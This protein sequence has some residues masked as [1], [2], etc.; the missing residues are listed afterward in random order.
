METTRIFKNHILTAQN[1]ANV[2][3][4]IVAAAAKPSDR[5]VNTQQQLRALLATNP[6]LF[7]FVFISFPVCSPKKGKENALAIKTTTPGCPLEKCEE[8][9]E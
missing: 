2:T 1:V 5:F 4:C 8:L 7:A 3:T 9:L 6:L